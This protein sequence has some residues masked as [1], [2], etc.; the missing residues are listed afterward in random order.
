MVVGR[1]S[2][3]YGMSP[4]KSSGFRG[5]SPNR[6]VRLSCGLLSC[7]KNTLVIF[8]RQFKTAGLRVE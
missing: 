5:A 8:G 1:A 4:N 2:R 6:T 3:G 7:E